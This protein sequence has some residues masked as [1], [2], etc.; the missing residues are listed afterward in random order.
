MILF[1]GMNE[2]EYLINDLKCLDFPHKYCIYKLSLIVYWIR[3]S[4]ILLRAI[5]INIFLMKYFVQQRFISIR[6]VIKTNM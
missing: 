5:P 6:F 4:E 2:L 1:Y 3:F